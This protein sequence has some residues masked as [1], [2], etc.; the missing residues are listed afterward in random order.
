MS[1]EKRSNIVGLIRIA[2]KPA[3]LL[4]NKGDKASTHAASVEPALAL[5]KYQEAFSCY[6]KARQA[7]DELT[8]ALKET[9]I[10]LLWS[11]EVNNEL[12][13]IH[14]RINSITKLNQ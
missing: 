14:G 11:H 12:E 6:Q 8:D 5:V 3:M 10:W 7:L 9:E 13:F 1:F 2:L 4:I